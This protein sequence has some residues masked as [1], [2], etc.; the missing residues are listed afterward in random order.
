MYLR[1]LLYFSAALSLVY[2]LGFLLVPDAIASA[3][4]AKLDATAIAI[5]RYWAATLVGLSWVLWTAARTSGSP[6]KLTLCRGLE[7]IGIIYLVVTWLT[8]QTGVINTTGAIA[9]FVIAVIYTVGFGYY[10]WAKKDAAL[11]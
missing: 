11:V 8:L 2:G 4:G 6:L 5:A 9:N 1:W 10:G 3:Y 7:V